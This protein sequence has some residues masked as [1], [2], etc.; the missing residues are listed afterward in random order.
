MKFA[1]IVPRADITVEA[2]NVR[3]GKIAKAA[4]VQSFEGAIDGKIVDLLAPL[5]RTLDASERAVHRVVLGA[6]I[7]EAILHPHVN[8]SA[9]RIEAERWIVGHDGDRPDGGRRDQIPVDGVTGRFVD[10]H[11]V[12]VDRERLRGSGDR[13]RDKTAKLYVRLEWIAANF[14]D[15]DAGHLLLQSVRDVQRPGALDLAGTKRV[16]ACRH[17]VDIY[18]RGRRRRGR[19]RVDNDPPQGSDRPSMR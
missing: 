18:S 16:D 10:A 15:D 1:G 7:V 5:R 14:A 4:V 11:A 17:L 19:G 3:R 8:R 2:A 6:L 12:L 13:G 9:Q